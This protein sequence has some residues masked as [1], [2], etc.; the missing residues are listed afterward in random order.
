MSDD[1]QETAFLKHCIGYDDTDE[2]YWLDERLTQIER[3]QLCVR[4]SVWLMT[5]LAAMAI[6]S[7]CYAAVF[8]AEDPINL[9][10][11]ADLILIKAVCAL[12]AGSL[13]CLFGF[14]ILGRLFRKELNR[15][16]EDCRRLVLKVLDSQ[17]RRRALP[18]LS[19]D[20]SGDTILPRAPG[21]ATKNSEPIEMKEGVS[22]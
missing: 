5:L 10:Q 16:R 7:L 21:I 13:F 2:R 1:Q 4:R 20:A 12:G 18:L 9:P 22:L 3:D 14:L 8:F 6:A 11:L 15:R 17:P 19:P